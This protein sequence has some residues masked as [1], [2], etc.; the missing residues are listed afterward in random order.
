MAE[1]YFTPSFSFLKNHPSRT[2]C[3]KQ[4]V[5]A[6]EGRWIQARKPKKEEKTAQQPLPQPPST[7]TTNMKWRK[8]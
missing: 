2:H 3:E 1:K 7:A 5:V 6:S 8:Q 4:T